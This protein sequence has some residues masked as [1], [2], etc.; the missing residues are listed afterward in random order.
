LWC[1]LGDVVVNAGSATLFSNLRCSEFPLG[2]LRHCFTL[3]FQIEALN[4]DSVHAGVKPKDAEPTRR[5]R[6]GKYVNYWTMRSAWTKQGR[7]FV[8]ETL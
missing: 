5:K 4:V 3:Y 1:G 8:V 7:Y 6:G 2:R